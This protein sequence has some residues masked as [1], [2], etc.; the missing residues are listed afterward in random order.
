MISFHAYV[1]SDNIR[2]TCQHSLSIVSEA[3]APFTVKSG[4]VEVISH[5]GHSIH[6]V[7]KSKFW[8]IKPV[9]CSNEK[10]FLP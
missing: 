8:D 5:H 4:M 10:A 3:E 2:T 9:I 7:F 1:N 6:H